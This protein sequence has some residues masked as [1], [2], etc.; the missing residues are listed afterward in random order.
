[1]SENQPKSQL[2][3]S[4]EISDETIRHFLLGQ[5]NPNEQSKFEESLFTDSD[6]EDRVRA[7]EYELSDDFAAEHLSAPEREL[8]RQKFLLT[9]ERN[10]ALDVSRALHARFPAP[11]RTEARVAITKKLK[12]FFDLKRPAWKYAFAAAILLLV[13]AT[14]L[15]V[16]KEPQIAYEFI[17]PRF[18]PRP[19]GTATPVPSHH[20]VAPPSPNHVEQS[21]PMLPHEGP[22]LQIALNAGTSREQSPLVTLPAPE[23][24]FVRFL[25]SMGNTQGGTYR[26]DLSAIGGDTVFR[27]ESLKPSETTPATISFDVERQNLKGGDYQITLTR[28]DDASNTVRLY[29]FR[30][31]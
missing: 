17:P 11:P 25:L 19:A 21:P 23:N 14:V 20:S 24:A 29:Y 6:L 3:G 2:N 8:F 26:A 16:T 27:V 30:V 4:R 5:L 7:A 10:R 28:I 18:R 1:M 12:T 9:A 13:F 22:A 31:Q 15:L